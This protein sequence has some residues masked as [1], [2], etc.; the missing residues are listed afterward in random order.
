[1]SFADDMSQRI[2]EVL[3][4]NT[5]LDAANRFLV[6]SLILDATKVITYEEQSTAALIALDE[7]TSEYERLI[8][9]MGELRDENKMMERRIV[10]L[11]DHVDELE[12]DVDDRD[13]QIEELEGDLGGAQER[14][15]EL[16][17]HVTEL[18][19]ELEKAEEER[20]DFD[21]DKCDE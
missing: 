1:M 13:S 7:K 9:E 10:D 19:N 11:E 6:S 3:E 16:E 2:E 18:E 5:V 17:D 15:D 4:K 14:A 8:N 20:C 12:S 21:C